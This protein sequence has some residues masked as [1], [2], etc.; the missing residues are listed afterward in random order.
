MV[1]YAYLFE[2]KGIQRYI[3]EGGKLKDM[4]GASELVAALCRSARH[5]ML[6]GADSPEPPDLIPPPPSPV[7]I[8]SGMIARAP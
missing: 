8:L 4:A 6:E 3:F 7:G 2:A 5:E 1:S